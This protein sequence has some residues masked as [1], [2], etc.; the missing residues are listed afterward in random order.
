MPHRDPQTLGL[1]PPTPDSDLMDG[2]LCLSVSP[3]PGVVCVSWRGITYR[4]DPA[5]TAPEAHPIA[6]G[7]KVSIAF[8]DKAIEIADKL[9]VDPNYLMAAMAFESGGTFSASVLNAAGSGAVGLIQFMPTTATALGTTSEDLADMAA[10]DQLD[11]VYEYFKPYTGRLKSLDDV[12]MAILF[13]AAIGQPESYVLFDQD[14]KKH[15]KRYAQN[16]GLDANKDGK[17][18]KAEA[19]AA[20]RAKLKAGLLPKNFG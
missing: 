2:T 17:I 18:T 12:Y 19:A 4:P 10:E 14:D 9:G 16:Q 15:P 5:S 8:K 13:P 7:K 20:V 6:F 1:E 11:Y 3:L